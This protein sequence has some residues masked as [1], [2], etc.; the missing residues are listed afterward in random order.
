MLHEW[1]PDKCLTGYLAGLP[2]A[3][4]RAL[5]WGLVQ[6]DGHTRHLDGRLTFIQKDKETVDWFQIVA[7]RAGYTTKVFVRENGVSQVHMTDRDQ[8]GLY[9]NSF[10]VENVHYE[11]RVWCP[12]THYGTWVARRNGAVFIT[13][14]TYGMMK[15]GIDI[16]RLDGGIDAT[17]Q[18]DAIQLV[19]RIRRPHEGKRDALWITLVDSR[20]DRS[21]RY[22]GSRLEEYRSAGMEV[23]DGVG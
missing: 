10:A 13:G 23:M 18:S 8:L 14:N 17:P 20:C 4:L 9:D 12:V 2:E 3:E 22:Y 5:F 11:G 6:G 1:C 21:I 19:G 7:M 15:E 16:P